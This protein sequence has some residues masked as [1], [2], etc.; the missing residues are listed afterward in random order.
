MMMIGASQIDITPEI[1]FPIQGHYY[2]RTGRKVLDPLYA[3]CAIVDDGKT[4]VEGR[5]PVE[6]KQARCF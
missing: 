1:P 6:C 2:L 5:G 3:S 4:A